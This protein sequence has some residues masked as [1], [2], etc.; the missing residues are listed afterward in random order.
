M[1]Q[2]NLALAV[3]EGIYL[4]IAESA[5]APAAGRAHRRAL[6]VPNAE[7]QRKSLVNY[8]TFSSECFCQFCPESAE[9]NEF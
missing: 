7:N 1:H 6:L 8:K 4:S 9:M 2:S 3:S 5:P